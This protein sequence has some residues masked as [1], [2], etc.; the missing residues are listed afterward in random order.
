M[1]RKKRAAVSLHPGV[2]SARFL[3]IHYSLSSQNKLYGLEDDW[4]D[5]R[6]IAEGTRLLFVILL[7]SIMEN[8]LYFA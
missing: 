3:C 5:P 6:A 4:P 2:H 7:D 1:A 8:N